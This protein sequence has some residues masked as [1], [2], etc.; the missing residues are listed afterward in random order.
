MAIT[1][2]EQ[3]LNLCAEAIK[4]EEMH[5]GMVCR[6]YCFGNEMILSGDKDRWGEL[7]EYYRT[8]IPTNL[9]AVGILGGHTTF[10]QHIPRSLISYP[11]LADPSII[12]DSKN[13]VLQDFQKE[14]ELDVFRAHCIMGLA[15]VEN[16]PGSVLFLSGGR[17]RR[18]SNWHEA[19]TYGVMLQKLADIVGVD[20]G[21]KNILKELSALNTFGNYYF[22]IEEALKLY[23][24]ISENMTIANIGWSTKAERANSIVAGLNSNR[25]QITNFYYF[26]AGQFVKDETDKVLEHASLQMQQQQRAYIR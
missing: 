12:F 10:K 7:F 11:E 2:Q 26:G 21:K 14:W 8:N 6:H 5:E 18:E 23:P 4:V 15:F 17:S 1:S 9:G 13:F 16:N 19:D 25:Y 3:A 22:S 20:I 24:N